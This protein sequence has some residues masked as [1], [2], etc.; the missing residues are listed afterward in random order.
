MSKR[1]Y[2]WAP[3]GKPP[4]IWQ[5]SVAK[6]DILSA[7]LIDYFQT[8]IASPH[9]DRFRLTLVDG[10]A[11]GG[12]YHH[13]KTGA[14]VLGSPFVMMKAVEDARVLVNQSRPRPVHFDVDYFFIEADVG[15][16]QVLRNE[17]RDR[18]HAARLGE[19][20]IVQNALFEAESDAIISHILARSPRAARA[21]FLLDQYGYAQVPT[22][23]IRGLFQR[24]PGAEVILT[25]AVDSF[26]NFADGG[27][28][29]RQTLE[30]LVMPDIFRGRTLEDIKSSEKDW[31][32]LIQS[33][34]Y[35]YLVH[36]CGARFH[37]TFFM[38][39]SKGHGDYWLLHLSQRARA[40][41]VMTRI[42]WQKNNCFIHYGGAGLDMFNILGYAPDKD[43]TYTGQG[44]L[45][46]G[47][48]FDEPAKAASVAGLMEQIPRL[49][50]P[51]AEGLSFGELFASTCNLSPA[52]ANIYREAIGNL[53]Q[54][55]EIE[56]VS[57][58]G[59]TRRTGTRIHDSD[60]VI[61]P[62][63]RVFRF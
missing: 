9:Q 32:L 54:H 44:S 11:G 46:F 40:R 22:S 10:F 33:S 1:H 17:L 34:M 35:Q 13:A 52:S 18:G 61:A 51:D 23:L 41:D 55:K 37:T 25:F 14:E 36:A 6:H 49:I 4:T 12:I 3:G 62:R 63:Q 58:N 15:A 21:I 24:L 7:Y 26:L 59:V 8:L 39:S 30:R 29:T 27:T 5:H 50:Y 48:Q 47:F 42:H 38:R 28:R 43:G 60:Q 57:Q 56:V 2:E 19:S 45:S 31:R 53:V 20:L 16:Y